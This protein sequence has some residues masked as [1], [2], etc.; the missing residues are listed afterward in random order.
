M[1][2][3]E[4]TLEDDFTIGAVDHE[5]IEQ[6]GQ[7]AKR[8]DLAHWS[9]DDYRA[10]LDRTDSI[11]LR[12]YDPIG[13]IFG[14]IVGRIVTG[15]TDHH[16][17]EVEIYNVAVEKDFRQ[18]GIGTK[19]M[20]GFFNECRQLGVSSVWLELRRRNKSAK[21]FYESLGFSEI[22]V[23]PEFYSDPVDDA[24]VMNTII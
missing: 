11:F 17:F 15:S 5:S 3:D 14:F 13:K 4:N 2:S 12:C 8:S 1:Y 7:I 6:I 10:E 20:Q 22:T 23:R 9:E 21:K 19:L 16:D 18:K 24:I